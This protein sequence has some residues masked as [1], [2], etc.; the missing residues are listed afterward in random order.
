MLKLN[1]M[2]RKYNFISSEEISSKH[3]N[4]RSIFLFFIFLIFIILFHSCVNIRGAAQDGNFEKVKKCIERGD[5]VNE[6][7]YFEGETPLIVAAGGGHFDIVKYLIEHG[8]NVNSQAAGFILEYSKE[9]NQG[10]YQFSIAKVSNGDTPLTQAMRGYPNWVEIIEYLLEHGAK[11]NFQYISLSAQPIFWDNSGHTSYG[12]GTGNIKP[13]KEQT[14][15]PL[16]KITKNYLHWHSLNDIKQET[17]AKSVLILFL[18]FGAD[19]SL[20]DGDGKTAYEIA[21]TNNLFDIVELLKP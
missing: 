17:K 9:I 3:K 15:T 12:L 7:R 1:L 16:T 10:Y 8:A 4:S 13:K 2:E 11:L 5:N 6:N 14:D 18:K 21:K 19:K 20:K